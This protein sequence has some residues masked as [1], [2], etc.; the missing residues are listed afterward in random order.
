M[1]DCE[2][3]E[4]KTL[5]PNIP[6]YTTKFI[7]IPSSEHNF[8][9]AKKATNKVPDLISNAKSPLGDIKSKYRL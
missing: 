8:T 5:I 2:E 7:D 4:D 3:E 1:V 6:K 9:V